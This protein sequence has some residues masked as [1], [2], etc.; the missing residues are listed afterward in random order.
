MSKTVIKLD[1][2]WRAYL[3]SLGANAGFV[4]GLIYQYLEDPAQVDE[5]WRRTFDGVGSG[6][7][8]NG[9]QPVT[10]TDAG[11]SSRG[12]EPVLRNVPPAEPSKALDEAGQVVP[13]QG[14]AVKIAENMQASLTVPTA[15]S[16][17]HIPVKVI[18]E[19]RR[20]IN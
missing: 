16:Q 14:A 8:L 12:Q 4:E 10:V 17:R 15:T 2:G 3:D 9:G 5:R 19:N 13:L 11:A 1:E 18:D 20:L 7:K 6:R